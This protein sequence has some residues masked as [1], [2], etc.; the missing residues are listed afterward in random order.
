MYTLWLSHKIPIFTY[1]LTISKTKASSS[2]RQPRQ[3]EGISS[4]IKMMTTFKI[5]ALFLLTAMM[6]VPGSLGLYDP[7]ES[8]YSLAA[9]EEFFLSCPDYPN[10][11]CLKKDTFIAPFVQMAAGN[12]AKDMYCDDNP[13]AI[14]CHSVFRFRK[15]SHSLRG[16]RGLAH[17]I[18]TTENMESSGTMLLYSGMCHMRHL[19]GSDEVPEEER[20]EER[21][22][23]WGDWGDEA[24]SEETCDPSALVPKFKRIN[25]FDFLR[26]ESP[27][28]CLN[29]PCGVWYRGLPDV[30]EWDYYA[31]IEMGRE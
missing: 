10:L 5:I 21:G 12:E 19:D 2:S 7:Q 29:V 20:V 25:L 9:D 8:E 30:D 24:T 15:K 28:S 27:Y 22:A 11:D 14:G 17:N 23:G 26:H 4:L 6:L 3:N 31:D 16:L 1:N 18:C 13:C